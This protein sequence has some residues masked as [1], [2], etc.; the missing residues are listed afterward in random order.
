MAWK[1]ACN[2]SN[3]DWALHCSECCRAKEI[4]AVPAQGS[5]PAQP[6]KA[7]GGIAGWQVMAVGGVLILGIVFGVSFAVAAFGTGERRA[8][9]ETQS[10]AA[11]KSGFQEA[12]DESFK[13]SCRQSAMRTATIS[14]SVA[15]R[16]C[17]CALTVFHETHSMTQAATT[18]SQRVRR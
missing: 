5:T 8:T 18:C 12:F 16:Y 17:E 15:D 2:A 1:C 7:F 13:T 14:Q 10:S 4:A 6:P 9:A 3:E 11:T